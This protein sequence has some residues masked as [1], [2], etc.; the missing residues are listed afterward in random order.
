M[1]VIGRE[2]P[3]SKWCKGNWNQYQMRKTEM[4]KVANPNPATKP[5]SF[6]L[7]YAHTTNII[8]YGPVFIRFTR[9]NQRERAMIKPHIYESHA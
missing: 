6:K 3:G 1:R 9:R 2:I 5:A 4:T 8:K 7:L